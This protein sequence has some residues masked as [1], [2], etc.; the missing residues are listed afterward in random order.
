MFK[1]PGFYV[2]YLIG[3][4]R[5]QYRGLMRV[6]I[7]FVKLPIALIDFVFPMCSILESITC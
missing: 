3:G 6:S 1:N 7:I 2:N 4:T 5:R